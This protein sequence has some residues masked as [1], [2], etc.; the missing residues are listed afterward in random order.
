TGL[1]SISIYDEMGRLIHQE[2]SMRS[3]GSYSRDLDLSQ[4]PSGFYFCRLSIGTS[5]VTHPIAVIH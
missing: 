4:V 3:T 5:S 2:R 1:V